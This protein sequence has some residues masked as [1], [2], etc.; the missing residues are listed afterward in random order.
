VNRTSGSLDVEKVRDPPGASAP[1]A[2]RRLEEVPLSAGVPP[3][4][5][6]EGTAGSGTKKGIFYR[7]LPVLQRAASG[8][9]PAEDPA[10][11]RPD[12]AQ[13]ALPRAIL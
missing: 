2:G 4:A 7:S 10:G 9:R 8:A 6:M 12:L 5:R 3:H 13:R 1:T 11:D